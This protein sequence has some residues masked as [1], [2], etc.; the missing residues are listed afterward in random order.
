ME[1]Y[2]L[3]KYIIPNNWGM[4]KFGELPIASAAVNVTYSEGAWS[5]K[6]LT[7]TFNQD[8]YDTPNVPIILNKDL[9]LELSNQVSLSQKTISGKTITYVVNDINNVNRND[10]LSVSYDKPLGVGLNNGIYNN[11]LY[12]WFGFEIY[13]FSNFPVINN[14]GLFHQ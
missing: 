14:Y 4:D 6:K 8:I 10:G 11:I 1:M 7:L 12:N 5:N 13:S 9:E 2:A 3:Q